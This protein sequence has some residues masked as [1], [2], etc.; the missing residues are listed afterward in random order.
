FGRLR[1]R[2]R[3]YL[4]A[5]IRCVVNPCPA[6]LEWQARGAH[7]APFMD[8]ISKEI[9]SPQLF[10]LQ[11]FCYRANRCGRQLEVS[12][13]LVEFVARN[14]RKP[15]ADQLINLFRVFHS[16]R[17]ETPEARFLSPCGLAHGF[18][19]PEPFLFA[20]SYQAYRAILTR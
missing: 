16:H 11:S 14:I 1:H 20:D 19:H 18:H 9:P 17:T 7:R 4:S 10:V 3:E 15:L 8:I 12:S 13:Y 5:F 6:D 2:T